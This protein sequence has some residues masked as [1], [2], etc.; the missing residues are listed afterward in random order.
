[1]KRLIALVGLPLLLLGGC[2]NSAPP[3]PRDHYYRVLIPAPVRND[4]PML[5]GV[6]EVAPLDA[7]GLLR[8]R[9]LLY[10]ASGQAYDM[11][12]HDYHYWVEPPPRMLQI[13]LVDYLRLT[14]FAATIVTPDLR[15]RADYELTGRIKRLE[16]LLGGGPPRVVAE[17]ELALVESTSKR[18]LLVR[19]YAAEVPSDDESVTASIAALNVAISE[20][21]ERFLV[22]AAQ[23]RTADLTP[24]SD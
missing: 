24:D 5:Q 9:P 20:I 14:G 23:S 15:I 4:A 11:Q 1:M 6:L 7:D 21:F 10:S 13:Q 17:L 16:R 2:L 18:L 12:Q 22:D 19:N 8:E 3:V